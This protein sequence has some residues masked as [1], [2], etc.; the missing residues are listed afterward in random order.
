MMCKSIFFNFIM[1]KNDKLNIKKNQNVRS[2]FL[3]FKRDET[4]H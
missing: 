2:C 3:R 1:I 4:L